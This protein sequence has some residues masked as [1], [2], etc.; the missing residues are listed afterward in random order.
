MWKGAFV[1]AVALTTGMISLASAQSQLP[2]VPSIEGLAPTGPLVT[3]AHIARLKSILNLTPDQQP[4]WAPVEAA[5]R[6]FSR[7][8]KGESS[9]G[10]VQRMSDQTTMA[11]GMVMRIRRLTAVAGPLIRTLDDVQKRDATMFVRHFGFDSLV[12]SF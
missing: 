6:A 3:E 2:S 4:Y 1:L 9:A 7:Q 8:H 11:A 10:F 5:L 12:A